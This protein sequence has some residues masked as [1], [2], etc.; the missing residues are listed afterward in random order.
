MTVPPRRIERRS[1]TNRTGSRASRQ[2]RIGCQN[3]AA[4]P[5][6]GEPAR[7]SSIPVMATPAPAATCQRVVRR[8]T[9]ST[10]GAASETTAAARVSA[11]TSRA[12]LE[13]LPFP[14]VGLTTPTMLPARPP[15]AL[16]ISRPSAGAADSR[17]VRSTAH[18][19]AA[20]LAPTRIQASATPGTAGAST[21]PSAAAAR[22]APRPPSTTANARARAW[23]APRRRSRRAVSV[24]CCRSPRT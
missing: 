22:P 6:V 3:A 20:A 4:R 17:C 12:G 19:A 15:A 14:A 9:P 8:M 13:P 11:A 1:T 18:A 10:L 21:S 7:N 5:D 23:G 24:I 2:V 16:S